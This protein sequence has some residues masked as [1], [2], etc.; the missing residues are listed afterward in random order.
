MKNTIVKVSI[1]IITFFSFTNV[2]AKENR[3]NSNIY[4]MNKYGVSLSEHEYNFL[5]QLFWEG[6]QDLMTVKDYNNFISSKLIDKEIETKKLLI[7]PLSQ[8]YNDGTEELKISKVCSSNCYISVTLTWLKLPTV[9]SYDVMGAYLDGTSL[10]G[11]PTTTIDT[12]SSSLVSNYKYFINGFGNSIK[13]QDNTKV[14][15]QTFRVNKG[16]TVYATYQH[17]NSSISLANSQN[18]T[19]SKSG[20]GHVFAFSGTA[21]SIYDNFGGVD[22]S[23]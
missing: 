19:I 14:V 17:A 15:N 16:G 12:G 9:K 13:L 11:E 20:Y 5:S 7:V 2:N 1:I 3:N 8:S 22:I 21:K 18:Y 23:V 4:Y 6:C 10:I